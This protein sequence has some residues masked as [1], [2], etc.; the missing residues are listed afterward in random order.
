MNAA[1]CSEVIVK[2]V[3]SFGDVSGADFGFTVQNGTLLKGMM[4]ACKEALFSAED[5]HNMRSKLIRCL[6]SSEGIITVEILEDCA[7]QSPF[8]RL[9]L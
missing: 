1:M 5:C 7:V 2:A 6:Q 3:P 4:S 9:P 8:E